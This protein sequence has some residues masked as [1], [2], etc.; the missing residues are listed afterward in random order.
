MEKKSMSKKMKAL[1]AIGIAVVVLVTAG[2]IGWVICN[3]ERKPEQPRTAGFY[4]LE[5][6]YNNGW[7]SRTDLK[8]IAY[9]YHKNT[10]YE[11][12]YF[13]PIPKDPE[14]LDEETENRLT[15]AYRDALLLWGVE[16]V[17]VNGNPD[18]IHVKR[19]YGTYS[20]CITVSVT[21]DYIK[22]YPIIKSRYYI[23]GV[24]FRNY[25]ASYICIWIEAAG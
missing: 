6:A 16:E 11:D 15:L 10:R 20:G 25:S 24:L 22:A 5:E 19:Y 14:V 23:G 13:V 21:V 12:K 7:I 4:F 8:N 18:G 2:M 17:Y 9:Y 1:V 3:P